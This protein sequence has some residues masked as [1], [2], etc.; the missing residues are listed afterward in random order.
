MDKPK[1]PFF[2]VKD[3]EVFG[4]GA[5]RKIHLK[6]LHKSHPFRLIRHGGNFLP[7]VPEQTLTWLKPEET[8]EKFLPYSDPFFTKQLHQRFQEIFPRGQALLADL[9]IKILDDYLQEMP[10][11]EGLIDDH[12]RYFAFFLRTRFPSHQSWQEVFICEWSRWSRRYLDLPWSEK[13]SAQGFELNPSL[14]F[15]RLGAEAADFLK[16][17]TG[18]YACFFNTLENKM[19]EHRVRKDQAR[20]LDLLEEEMGFSRNKIIQ[21]LTEDLKSSEAAQTTLQSLEVLGILREGIL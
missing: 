15:Y 14:Q 17:D 5:E 8:Q 4:V 18:L 3:Y 10:W 2:E 7:G 19:Q 21:V 9:Q 1:D 12:F 13:A 11:Q 20:A 6:E 16:M